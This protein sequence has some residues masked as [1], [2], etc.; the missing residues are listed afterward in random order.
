[1]G[2]F[3]QTTKTIDLGGGNTVVLRKATFGDSQAASSAAM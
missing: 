1:M 3:T 2:F